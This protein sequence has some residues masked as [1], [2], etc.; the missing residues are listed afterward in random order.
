MSTER[1]CLGGGGG[2][3]N[4]R[5]QQVIYKSQ[6]LFVEFQKVWIIYQWIFLKNMNF[7]HL[8]FSFKSRVK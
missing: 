4:Q 6:K 5:V 8:F 7:I 3:S 1:L 2:S